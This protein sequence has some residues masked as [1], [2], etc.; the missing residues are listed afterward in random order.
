MAVKAEEICGYP[1]PGNFALSFVNGRDIRRWKRQRIVRQYPYRFR[2][3]A[4]RGV[5]R[6][7]GPCARQAQQPYCL[8]KGKLM[9]LFQQIPFYMI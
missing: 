3:A 7:L 9:A 6:G 2:L 4:I 8:D 5:E 1:E